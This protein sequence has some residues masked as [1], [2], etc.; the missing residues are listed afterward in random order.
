MVNSGEG[1]DGSGEQYMLKAELLRRTPSG[2][3][4]VSAADAI[5]LRPTGDCAMTQDMLRM[6]VMALAVCVFCAAI[7]SS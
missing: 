4:P 1:L 7:R 6:A 2:P 5:R 3:K